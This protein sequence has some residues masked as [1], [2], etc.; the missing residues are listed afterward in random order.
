MIEAAASLSEASRI[1]PVVLVSYSAGS[2]VKLRLNGACPPFEGSSDEPPAAPGTG[3]S[4]NDERNRRY[5]WPDGGSRSRITSG[6]RDGPS[7]WTMRPSQVSG[8]IVVVS[9]RDRNRREGEPRK[10]L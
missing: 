4:S 9:S 7:T 8:L 6:S 1:G 10:P 5:D 3:S 2:N